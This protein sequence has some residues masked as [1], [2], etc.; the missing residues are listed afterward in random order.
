MKKNEINR[1]KTMKKH[2]LFSLDRTMM[3]NQHLKTKY[4]QKNEHSNIYIQMQSI[5]IQWD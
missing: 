3:Q 5:Q 2:K 4:K 1:K